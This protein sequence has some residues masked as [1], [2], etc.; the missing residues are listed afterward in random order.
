[1]EKRRQTSILTFCTAKRKLHDVP[2][3]GDDV[4]DVEQIEHSNDETGLLSG[5]TQSASTV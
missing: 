4:G 1:M 3:S 5:L 2:P